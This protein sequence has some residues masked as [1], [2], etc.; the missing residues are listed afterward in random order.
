MLY[1]MTGYGDATWE[2]EG[3][4]LC[5]EIRSLNNRFLKSTIKLPDALA[6]A[7]PE[8]SRVIRDEICRG[9]VTYTLH[10][11]MT[12]DGSA[13]DVN[14]AAV[15]H[16]L[17]HLEGAQEANKSNANVTIDMATLMQLPGVCRP[18]VYTDKE[19]R[20]FLDIIMKLTKEALADLRAMR[21][22]EGQGLRAD[23][24]KQ[25]A[26]MRD[27]LEALLELSERV[28]REYHRRLQQRVQEMLS[29]AN[30]KLDDDMLAKEVA[31]YAERCDIHEESQ[32]LTSHLDTFAEAC[33]SDDNGQTGRRLDFMT[34][35][36]LR[37]ANTIG[38]K[39][40]D[41]EISQHVVEI[42]VAIDRLKEQV[43]NVE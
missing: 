16:Y 23:L 22:E 28:P 8:V 1:S 39:A 7:E 41:A 12:D 42:K 37:E 5:V 3:L 2:D 43:Q 29:Q 9:S 35:E 15:R 34:Q 30:L 40:N 17:R 33:V 13:F 26:A 27:H 19:N 21:A 14:E 10:M 6:F 11:R 4:S 31:L 38:S 36:M 25:L 18:R 20:Q 24:E 32:R